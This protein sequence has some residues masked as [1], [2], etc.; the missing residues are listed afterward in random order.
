MGDIAFNIL[1]FFVILAR[2]NDDSY[3][4]WRPAR[5]DE[6][7]AAGYSKVSVLIDTENRLYLNGH[8]VGVASLAD[9]IQELLG[10]APV[11][12]RTV[13]LKVDSEAQ[14]LHYEPV[15]EAISQAGGDLVH[16]LEQQRKPQ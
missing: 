4:K 1:I 15:I 7:E 6:V 14:A 13:M 3:L 12:Q 16:V 11:G 9:Q 10:N 8:Q 5:S 2:A